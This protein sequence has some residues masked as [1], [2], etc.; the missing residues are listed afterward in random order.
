MSERFTLNTDDVKKW[1]KNAVIFSAPAL[2]VFLLSIQEGRSIEESL[3]V[4]KLWALNTAIDIL[5]KFIAGE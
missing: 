4:L 5:R 2:L 3:I 1:A